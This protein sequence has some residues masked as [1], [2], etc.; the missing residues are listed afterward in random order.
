MFDRNSLQIIGSCA[1]TPDVEN[2]PAVEVQDQQD[3]KEE[4]ETFEAPWIQVL[5]QNDEK[6]P[7]NAE[8]TSL[9]GISYQ[10]NLPNMMETIED[11]DRIGKNSLL[12]R[13]VVR[14]FL[15]VLTKMKEEL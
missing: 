15:L 14:N 11:A 2:T 10:K 6:C 8:D 13:Q 9:E 7:V 1:R 4:L 5:A 12:L 3:A